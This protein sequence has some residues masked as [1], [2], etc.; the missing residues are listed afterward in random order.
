MKTK[1]YTSKFAMRSQRAAVK[2]ESK[3]ERDYKQLAA[4][5][6]KEGRLKDAKVF[7]SHARD[8]ARHKRED[9]RIVNR[10]KKK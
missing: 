6:K 2:D 1:P 7:L 5:A 4:V 9:Q 8:E 3:G 10:R